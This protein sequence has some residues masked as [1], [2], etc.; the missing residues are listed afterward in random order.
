MNELTPDLVA[1]RQQLA[2][3]VHKL[4]LQIKNNPAA[5]ENVMLDDYL[6]AMSGFLT[7]MDGFYQNRGESMPDSPSWSMIGHILKAAATYE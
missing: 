3:F 5:Y 7:D 6:E 2:Q 4:R 1:N